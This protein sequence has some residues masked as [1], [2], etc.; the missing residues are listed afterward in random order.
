MGT[1]RNIST[2]YRDKKL[3]FKP[4]KEQQRRTLMMLLNPD[5]SKLRGEKLLKNYHVLRTEIFK[6]VILFF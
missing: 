6:T 3:I 1:K 4:L 5:G 2:N